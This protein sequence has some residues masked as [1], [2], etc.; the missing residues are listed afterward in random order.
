MQFTDAVKDCSDKFFFSLFL[1]FLSFTCFQRNPNP[2]GLFF[3]FPN[4]LDLGFE[5]HFSIHNVTKPSSSLTI[6]CIKEDYCNEEKWR[7]SGRNEDCSDELSIIDERKKLLTINGQLAKD[8]P[9]QELRRS[10]RKRTTNRR[11][12]KLGYVVHCGIDFLFFGP[13]F[14]ILFY[15]LCHSDILF[16]FIILGA[17]RPVYELKTVISI[18]TISFFI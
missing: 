7:V 9:I 8:Q 17:C 1:F 15:L 6:F 12:R 18:I 5:V 13:K 4:T 2:I 10:M 3:F 14:V 11:W 16:S